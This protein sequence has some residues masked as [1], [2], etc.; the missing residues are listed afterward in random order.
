MLASLRTGLVSYRTGS[1]SK[2]CAIA[3]GFAEAGADK[4]LIL[5]EDFIER[6]TIDPVQVRKSLAEVDSELQRAE[7]NESPHDAYARKRALAL[8]HNWYATQL[9]LHGDPPPPTVW[10]S[11]S[12]ELVTVQ[13]EDAE[14]EGS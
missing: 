14:S 12:D 9:E 13:Q 4:L 3:G 1:E 11:D 5:T 8:Q 10:V 7:A 2:R 6:D